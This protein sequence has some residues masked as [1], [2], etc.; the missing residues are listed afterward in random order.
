M[1]VRERER[2]ERND[3]EKE[4]NEMTERKRVTKRQ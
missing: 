3:S 4:R 1:K 2:E